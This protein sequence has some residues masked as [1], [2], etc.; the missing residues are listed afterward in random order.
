ML[1]TVRASLIALKLVFAGGALVTTMVAAPT[2]VLAAESAEADIAAAEAAFGQL[3]YEDAIKRA[4]S[5][6]KAGN[7]THD[8]LKRVYKVLAYAR[9]GTDQGDKARDAF[10]L[11]LT[12]EPD[13]VVDKSQGPKMEQPFL[14]ARGFWRGQ[15]T[16]PGIEASPLLRE[17]ESGTMR[18]TLR[19]PTRIVTKAV[20]AYRWGT[21]A[22]F[23]RS[24][25]AVGDQTITIPAAPSGTT[26]LDYFVQAFD[27]QHNA[28]FEL[29]NEGVPRTSMLE[30]S[31]RSAG[32]GK[33][34]EGG[35]IFGSPVFWVIA[36]VLVAGGATT[37]VLLAG[38]DKETKERIVNDPATRSN[39]GPILFC[40]TD[41]CR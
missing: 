5:A 33:K 1:R 19:D 32:A 29:G 2:P 37:A 8:Q 34:E 12:Y 38:G 22:P 27:A 10:V 26:R 4:E 40:G 24:D 31:S 39:V 35:S 36:G 18:V 28:V 14:E 7:L 23:R 21:A 9:A 25:I 3:A 11:L 41:R 13:F 6:I 17:G 30:V 15:P 16:K 20:V